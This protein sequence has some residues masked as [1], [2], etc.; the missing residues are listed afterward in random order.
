MEL[1]RVLTD[2]WAEAESKVAEVSRLEERVRTAEE[3]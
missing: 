3:D 2:D 1:S